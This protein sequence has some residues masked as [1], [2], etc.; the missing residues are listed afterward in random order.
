MRGDLN[1]T[2]LQITDRMVTAAVTEFQFI[3]GGSIGQ[4]DDLMSETNTEDG[5]FPD[6]I[7]ATVCGTSAGS[8]G[9]LEIKMPSGRN[10]SIAS[11]V[12]F[13]GTTVTLQPRLLRD[14]RIFNFIPQSMAT[15]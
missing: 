7:A 11:A 8:P 6:E 1:L 9:P 15:T 3:G 5:I 2:R 13:Q 4:R 12:V 10:L 14:R